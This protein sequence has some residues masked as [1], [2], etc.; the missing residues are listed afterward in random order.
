[1]L[2]TLDDELNVGIVG[3]RLVYEDGT[4]QHDGCMF[5][6]LPE[7]GNWPFP[8]HPGKGRSIER[9]VD[10]ADAAIV[11]GAC[12]VIRRALAVDLGGFDEGYVIGDFEDA[13]L[14]LRIVDKGL[15]CVVENRAEL[16]HLE[17]QSQNRQANAWRMNLTL[18]NAW[19]FQ[20]RWHDREF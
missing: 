9:K 16:Y 15:R 1:M 20:T 13:D 14:C 8:M 19:H 6:R 10:V 2:D 4:L 11:T 5:E 3:A 7:F 12:M 18:Y 17:R